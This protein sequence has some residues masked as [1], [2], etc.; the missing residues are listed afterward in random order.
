MTFATRLRPR[1]DAHRKHPRITQNRQGGPHRRRSAIHIPSLLMKLHIGELRHPVDGQKY[2]EPSFGMAKL[3]GIDV[4]ITDLGL[5]EASPLRCFLAIVG[6]P[7]DPVALEAA[8][9]GAS[10][11]CWDSL[12]QA[13]QHI[14]QR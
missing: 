4:D 9:Q 13:P 5:G 14:I 12:P 2:D 8:M 1:D 6:Q 11:Q 10:G 3:A 7:G